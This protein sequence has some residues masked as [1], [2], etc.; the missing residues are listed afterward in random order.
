MVKDK[1]LKNENNKGEMKS[2]TVSRSVRMRNFNQDLASNFATNI[3]VFNTFIKNV[4]I[5]GIRNKVKYIV[6]EQ[7]RVEISTVTD[8]SNLKT[9]FGEKDSLDIVELIQAL[10]DAFFP[11]SQYPNGMPDEDAEKLQTVG[12][13]INYIVLKTLNIKL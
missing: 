11:K 8:A 3:M 1:Q 7:F 9:G 2:N 6:A 12:D 13:V 4:L 5:F 10:E